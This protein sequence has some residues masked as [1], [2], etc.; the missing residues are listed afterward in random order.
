VE[1]PDTQLL[2][3]EIYA[4]IQG[5]SSY[6][7]RPCV[8]VRLTGCNLRCAYC[9]TEYAFY[10]GERRTVESVVS[11]VSGYG[12][13]LVLI[14]GGEPLLQ[15]ACVTLARRLLDANLLVLIETSGERPIDVLPAGVIRIMDIKCPS[16]GECEKMN[17]ENIAHLRKGDEAKFVIGDRTDY[18]WAC[19]VIREHGLPRRCAVLISTVFGKID[20][21]DVTQWMI[22][23]KLDARFQLQMHKYMWTPETRGV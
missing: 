20:P 10:G 18:D 1:T 13:P 22:D 14:T 9:D 12:I 5:E 4:S 2:V 7:G 16:S 6:A 15:K 3:H 17:W 8:F 23:D 19:G 21:K 11:E